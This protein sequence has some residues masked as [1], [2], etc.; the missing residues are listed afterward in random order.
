MRLHVGG[1]QTQHIQDWVLSQAKSEARWVRYLSK[2]HT[3]V[4]S[5]HP[6]KLLSVG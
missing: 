3:E 4:R 5:E 1:L 6:V 2:L